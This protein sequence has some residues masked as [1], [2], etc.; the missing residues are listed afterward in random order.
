[1]R[2]DMFP[3][4]MLSVRATVESGRE[5]EFNRWYDEEHVPDAVRMLPGC[6]GAAR[7]KVVMGDGSHQYMALYAFERAAK[8]ADALTGPEIRELIKIYD[9]DIGAFSTRG[10]TTY[11]R[12]L[13]HAKTS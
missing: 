10:R 5:I 12:V 8:L 6:F 3:E 13:L 4:H 7:Y 11:E 1:M 9:R 2:V